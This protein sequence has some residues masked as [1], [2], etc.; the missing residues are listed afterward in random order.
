MSARAAEVLAVDTVPQAAGAWTTR[1]L[2][3]MTGLRA[4]PGETMSAKLRHRLLR[5][6]RESAIDFAVVLAQDAVYREDGARDDAATDFD[7]ANDAVFALAR[8]CGKGL[9]ILPAAERYRVKCRGDIPRRAVRHRP[10]R[11]DRPRLPARVPILLRDG[12]PPSVLP[13]PSPRPRPRA[14]PPDAARLHF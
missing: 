8:E 11:P 4:E 9:L 7:V 3:W 5:H 12:L 6:L 14:A 1:V 13:P 2:L 10:R